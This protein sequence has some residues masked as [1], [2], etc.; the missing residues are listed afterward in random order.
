MYLS[1][2]HSTRFNYS[3]SLEVPVSHSNPYLSDNNTVRVW[4]SS[5][6]SSIS[7]QVWL[8]P[9]TCTELVQYHDE[10]FQS[11]QLLLSTE[12]FASEN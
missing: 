12:P 11:I 7:T 3:L 2:M 5:I 9:L 6:V 1:L 8:P 10:W 4:N